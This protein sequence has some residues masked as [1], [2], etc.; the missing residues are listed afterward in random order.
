MISVPQLHKL[1]VFFL[2]TGIFN[3]KSFAKRF[4]LISKI[5]L[6]V[7][8]VSKYHEWPFGLHRDVNECASPGRDRKYTVWSEM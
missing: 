6:L 7:H 8:G 2:K 1:L 5:E 3:K 4:F